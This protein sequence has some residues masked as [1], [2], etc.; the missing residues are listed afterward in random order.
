MPSYNLIAE[1]CHR[2]SSGIE[3]EENKTTE[4]NDDTVPKISE[5]KII[6]GETAIQDVL[7]KEK[8]TKKVREVYTKYENMLLDSAC[9]IDSS[10]LKISWI[11]EDLEI[12]KKMVS[13][14]IDSIDIDTKC[15]T[16]KEIGLTNSL[17]N[18]MINTTD[19]ISIKVIKIKKELEELEKM[20]L[21]KIRIDFKE[22]Y[23][24]L[25]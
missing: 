5:Y 7:E 8:M 19:R 6:E 21:S 10:V 16:L 17:F 20:D 1:D 4:K 18:N 3:L 13:N 14:L 22:E 25:L 2:M 15:Y 12:I 9:D 23:S 24:N 11:S